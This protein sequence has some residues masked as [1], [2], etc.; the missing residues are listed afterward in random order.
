MG[1]GLGL[2]W[3]WAGAGAGADGLW[4]SVPRRRKARSLRHLAVAGAHLATLATAAHVELQLVVNKPEAR[5]TRSPTASGRQIK[6]FSPKESL[7]ALSC[8]SRT[9]TQILMQGR[10]VTCWA[11][12]SEPKQVTIVLSQQQKEDKPTK[13]A[14]EVTH[15]I[16]R[17]LKLAWRSSQTETGRARPFM[18]I[19]VLLL[20]QEDS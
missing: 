15:P 19:A 6:A 2:G 5:A 3:G 16:K 14:G 20:E 7:C 17:T 8:L 18:Q 1:L 10:S 11:S 13:H 12:V 4:G 9:T